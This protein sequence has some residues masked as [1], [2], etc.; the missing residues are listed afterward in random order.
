MTIRIRGHWFI[1]AAAA[2]CVSVVMLY[3]APPGQAKPGDQTLKTSDGTQILAK[4]DGKGYTAFAA[5]TQAPL[6]DGEY[7]LSNGGAIRV[8][9]GRVVWDAFGVI[10][11]L[12]GKG[13]GKTQTVPALG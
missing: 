6:S 13:A 7:K 8:K 5:K 2:L 10:E 3:G 9:G 1:V 12:K 11:K 4:F